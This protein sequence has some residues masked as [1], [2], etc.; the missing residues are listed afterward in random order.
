MTPMRAK[1]LIFAAALAV[2]AAGASANTPRINFVRTIAPIH[3]LGADRVAIIYA[4]GDNAAIDDFVREL[5]DHVNRAGTMRI[6][7]AV[8]ANRH[9]SDFTSIGKEHH[10]GVYLGVNPFTCGGKERH[11]EGSEHDIDG[12]RV[13][14][15]H[16][17]IDAVCSA[18]I[19]VL[20]AG[21]G[22][23]ML[24][25]T[26]K[27]EGTSPRVTVLTNDE[28]N[29]A[30]GQAAHYAAVA[31]AESITPRGV[32]ES[33]ELD[34]TAPAFDEGWS[35]IAS[36]RLSDARAIWEAALRQHRDSA[37]LIFDLAA[38]CEATGDVAAAE[39]YFEL[40]RKIQ[41]RE[42]RYR[43]ELSLFHKR[44]PPKH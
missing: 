23:K 26:V 14:K 1:T 22:R 13:R 37:P 40:A 6:E 3:D 16:Y 41:P 35:M 38:L 25:F 27:G 18:R 43:S 20:R 11:A 21:D 4:L 24:S 17:W 10:A 7:N 29:V 32:R 31:A 33:I 30:F 19:D 34:P 12:G 8:E 36:E 5:V 42:Q 15:T 39:R 9:L 44:N 2:V 28:R